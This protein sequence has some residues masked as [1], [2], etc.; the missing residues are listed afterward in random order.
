[1]LYLRTNRTFKMIIRS[2]YTLSPSLRKTWKEF[3]QSEGSLSPFLHLDYISN[4]YKQVRLLGIWRG[5]FPIF[6]C[7]QSEKGETLLI[8]PLVK[9][10]LASS[11]RMLADIR[12]CGS[13]DFLYHP[14]LTEEE[15][16]ECLKALF[17]KLGNKWHLRRLPADSLLKAY[18]DTHAQTIKTRGCCRIPITNYE[19]WFGSLSPS[20]RQNIRTAYN[21]LKRD[22]H[23]F[24]LSIFGKYNFC[25]KSSEKE[26]KQAKEES[27]DLYIQRQITKY[28]NTGF[29]T[30]PI[31]KLAY[32]FLKHDSKSLYHNPNSI[33]V[34]LRID[35]KIA[36]YMGCLYS[37]D[38]SIIIV[39]RLAIDEQFRFYSP[40]YVM[41]H[42]FIKLLSTDTQVRILDLSRGVEKYKTDLGGQ[43][44]DTFN[45]KSK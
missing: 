32:N 13:S 39:P 2:Y 1:M 4:I 45:M 3:E 17:Q 7:V 40:G 43:V 28:Q 20:V 12:G 23:S 25:I 41:L 6:Y 8:A 35:N 27:L 24:E 14:K 33:T 36:A 30:T 16:T 18:L 44:Y 29:L 19:T 42:E 9:L 38:Q 37:H 10:L 22:N 5:A 26:L 15:R 34:I 21:R 31:K 11:Y